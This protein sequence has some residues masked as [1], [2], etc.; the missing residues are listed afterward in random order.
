MGFK[1]EINQRAYKLSWGWGGAWVREIRSFR[2]RGSCEQGRAG[3]EEWAGGFRCS[4]PPGQG[5]GLVWGYGE[6]GQGLNRSELKVAVRTPEYTPRT[7]G[8]LICSMFMLVTSHSKDPSSR[9]QV[10][11]P[12][13]RAH[14]LFLAASSSLFAKGERKSPLLP[15]G[16][17]TRPKAWLRES[18]KPEKNCQGFGV[19][20]QCIGCPRKGGVP[21]GSQ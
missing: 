15:A 3:T 4:H 1:G 7:T 20:E 19:G 11:D 8:S 14:I 18:K 12:A 9:E 6:A 21:Q 5:M 17:L 16:L 10:R 2:A 13:P